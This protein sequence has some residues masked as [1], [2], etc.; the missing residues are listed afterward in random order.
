MVTIAVREAENMV[1]G[2]LKK[3]VEVENGYW[4]GN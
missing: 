3:I 4:L 2:A 1:F